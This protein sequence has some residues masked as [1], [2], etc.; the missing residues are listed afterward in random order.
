MNTLLNKLNKKKSGKK[1]FTLMEMLIV[2]AIIAILIAIAIPTF[3]NALNKARQATDEANLRSYYAEEI[4]A[5]LLENDSLPTAG[6]GLTTCTVSGITY[7][8]QAGT[9]DITVVSSG[10][11]ADGS[12]K[13]DNFTITYNSNRGPKVSVTIPGGTTTDNNG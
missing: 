7:T 2:V 12:D 3:T 8:L 9:Y 5:Y 6:T 11:N 1:G 10:T 13:V 4:S